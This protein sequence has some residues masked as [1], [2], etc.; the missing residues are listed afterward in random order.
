MQT[1]QVKVAFNTRT[2]NKRIYLL[3]DSCSESSSALCE[4]THTAAGINCS[5]QYW[6]AKAGASQL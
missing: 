5:F 2:F 3:A 4:G 1:I 6:K